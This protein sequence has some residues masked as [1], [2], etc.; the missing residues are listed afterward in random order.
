M[1]E[2]EFKKKKKLAFKVLMLKLVY[3]MFSY[4]E[5]IIME[6]YLKL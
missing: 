1:R 2:I 5:M 6:K 3:L 4:Q